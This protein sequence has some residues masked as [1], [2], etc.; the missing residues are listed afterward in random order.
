MK[1]TVAFCVL[2]SQ[3]LSVMGCHPSA[4]QEQ[5]HQ[6]QQGKMQQPVVG[7]ER[8]SRHLLKNPSTSNATDH[9]KRYE[10][11]TTTYEQNNVRIFYE[12][13]VSLDTAILFYKHLS[14]RYSKEPVPFIFRMPLADDLYLVSAW[15]K[16]R[17][18]DLQRR[19]Y[20]FTKQG[21]EI[22]E[23]YRS[24]GWEGSWIL[25]PTFFIGTDH[26][27]IIAET[28]AEEFGGLEA[29]EFKD[30]NLKYLGPLSVAKKEKNAIDEDE[31][32]NPL[33]DA[34]AE[35][36]GNTYYITMKGDL[37]LNW[38]GPNKRKIGTP[39]SAVTFYYDGKRFRPW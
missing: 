30:R 4:P 12:R 6:E 22:V 28:E 19:F 36:K 31:F 35:F 37:Y 29:F 18:N 38:D 21:M 11:E 39:N 2:L 24:R 27:L 10:P 20:L 14:E 1:K 32:V 34:I 17:K 15:G 9:L 25:K 26:V 7:S 16:D 8:R 23:L 33:K 3:S 5:Q 13:G